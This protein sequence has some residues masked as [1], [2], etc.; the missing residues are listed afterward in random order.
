MP[1]DVRVADEKAYGLLARARDR[2]GQ[3]KFANERIGLGRRG[4]HHRAIEDLVG[5]HR[6]QE[7][8]LEVRFDDG[9]TGRRAEYLG[10]RR[11][12]APGYQGQNCDETDDPRQRITVCDFQNE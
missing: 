9:T 5:R 2:L 6:C 12:A 10:K 4:Q 7:Q 11:G 1:L 3:G 8:G